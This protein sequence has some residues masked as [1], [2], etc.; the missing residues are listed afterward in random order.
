MLD[1]ICLTNSVVI[2]AVLL[3]TFGTHMSTF[4]WFQGCAYAVVSAVQ[5]AVMF[6][7]RD[8]YQRHRFKVRS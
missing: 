8:L 5:L 2:S 7:Q 3:R 4:D 1:C 6:N